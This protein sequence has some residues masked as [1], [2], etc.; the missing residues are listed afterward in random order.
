MDSQRARSHLKWLLYGLCADP[1]TWWLPGPM[2]WWQMGRGDIFINQKSEQPLCFL[3]G[4]GNLSPGQWPNQPLNPNYSQDLPGQRLACLCC[5]AV[6]GG[7]PGSPAAHSVLAGL[8]VGAQDRE[9][10]LHGHHIGRWSAGPRH[11]DAA[12]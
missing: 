9:E 11:G 12:E 10:L 8:Q 5:A 6:G 7:L 2:V 4:I 1:D 3:S